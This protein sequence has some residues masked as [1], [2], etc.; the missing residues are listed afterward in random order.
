MTKA[1]RPQ[2]TKTTTIT[3]LSTSRY[4]APDTV[5]DSNFIRHFSRPRKG[6]NTTPVDTRLLATK[7]REKA[8]RSKK[9]RTHPPFQVL[10]P[11]AACKSLEDQDL[12]FG[13]SSQLE[14]DESP[15]LVGQTKLALRGSENLHT[16]APVQGSVLSQRSSFASVTDSLTARLSSSRNLWFMAARDCTGAL[17]QI[18]VVDLADSPKATVFPS[19]TDAPVANKESE[20][21]SLQDSWLDIDDGADK[22]PASAYSHVACPSINGEVSGTAKPASNKTVTQPPDLSKPVFRGFTTAEL[23]KRIAEF[24]FKP[25][26]GRDRMISVLEK[27]WE[28]QNKM[29]KVASQNAL[30]SSQR[31]E[32]TSHLEDESCGPQTEQ[33]SG[34]RDFPIPVSRESRTRSATK[35]VRSKK[36]NESSV[37]GSTAPPP[38]PQVQTSTIPSNRNETGCLSLPAHNKIEDLAEETI[39]STRRDRLPSD[40]T[41]STVQHSQHIATSE[42]LTELPEISRQITNAIR[43]QPRIRA[44][45]GVKQPTWYEKILM[46]DPVTL[47]DLA[48]W[49]NTEGLNRVGEDREVSAWLVREWCESKGV[50]CSWRKGSNGSR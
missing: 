17:A 22:V 43:A 50:C 18:D 36:N 20:T 19:K 4:E 29:K 7:P 13:T 9:T 6:G 38:K 37:K 23:A 34:S 11:V 10:S 5:N 39:P 48:A 14:R 46:F 21:A 30:A 28:N 3:A 25:M 42:N 33:S 49:L 27:C 15:K 26:K 41:S 47:E 31:S 45:N 1:K 8:A 32:S 44:N 40:T 2:K 12:L 24:G 16:A 35:Q